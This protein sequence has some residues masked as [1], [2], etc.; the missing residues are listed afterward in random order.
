MLLEWP[1]A[2]VVQHELALESTEDEEPTRDCSHLTAIIACLIDGRPRSL[3]EIDQFGMTRRSAYLDEN[4][5][6]R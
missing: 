3:V 4:R 6:R 1:P 5:L 2:S